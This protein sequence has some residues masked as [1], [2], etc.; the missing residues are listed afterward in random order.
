VTAGETEQKDTVAV[1][2]ARGWHRKL[3][4]QI[5][6]RIA[7]AALVL[8]V[9][10]IVFHL[11]SDEVFFT[12][13]NLSLLLRQASI[14][15][16]LAA[17]VSVLM[18]MAEIDLSIGSAVYLTGV[19]AGEIVVTHGQS[20]WVGVF[21]AIAA[22]VLLGAWNGFWVSRL[23]VPSFVVTLAGLMAF[24]GVGLMWTDAA[25]LGPL[26]ESFVNLSE[27]FLA[28]GPSYVA[29]IAFGGI[30]AFVVFRRHRVDIQR[31]GE[32]SNAQLGLRLGGIA[33][34]LG[35]ALWIAGGFLGLP[36]ALVWVIAVGAVLFVIMSQTT[37]GR[38]AYMIGANRE[39]AYLAGINVRRHIFLG[40]ILMGV[41]YGVCGVLLDARLSASSPSAGQFLELNAIAAAVIGGTSLMGGVGTIPGAMVG[42]LLLATID[43]GMN[44]LN[45]NSFAQL[46]VKGMILILAVALDQFANRRQRRA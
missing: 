37:F 43:N 15:A 2:A 7:S 19:V 40:F 28:K 42:A 31:H 18:I 34:L 36:Y 38:N 29:L 20:T 39:A 24:S 30:A 32:A 27:K 25:T 33:I 44:L 26:P 8:I 5:D 45:V 16:I 10:S 3:F 14:V 22:G 12:P 46:V 1:E 11:S 17:G 13:R 21:G 6:W 4:D 9:L 41:L 23:A 35:L